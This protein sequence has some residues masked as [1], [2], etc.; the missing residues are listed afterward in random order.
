[1]ERFNNVLGL[2][3]V[4]YNNARNEFDGHSGPFRIQDPATG[5]GPGIAQGLLI[6]THPIAF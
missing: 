4:T 3:E 6:L 1:M 5:G 2:V